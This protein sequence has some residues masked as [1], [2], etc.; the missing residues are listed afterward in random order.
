MPSQGEHRFKVI[1]FLNPE[2]CVLEYW[3]Q[4]E[5]C[6]ELKN[7]TNKS[8]RKEIPPT[9][10]ELWAEYDGASLQVTRGTFKP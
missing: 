6:R 9:V 8:N 4:L 2:P 10:Q 3:S 1:M 7:N 5:K